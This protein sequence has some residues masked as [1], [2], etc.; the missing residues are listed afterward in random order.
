MSKVFSV[1]DQALLNL[2][3]ALSDAGVL[4]SDL[5]GGFSLKELTDLIALGTD[6]STVI[7]TDGNIIPEW[8]TLSTAD[9]AELV[10]YISANCTI[11]ASTTATAWAQK[12]LSAAVLLSS[13]YQTFNK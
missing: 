5:M 13:I 1:T 4:T 3:K 2:L 9:Q 8:T 6:M 10:A 12:I 7:G 11:P